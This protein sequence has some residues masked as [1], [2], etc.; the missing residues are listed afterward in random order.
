MIDEY[1]FFDNYLQYYDLSIEELKR[2]KDHTMRVTSYSTL[3]ANELG[4]TR[5]SINLAQKIALFHDIGR[6]PQFTYFKTFND[7]NSIDHG[8]LSH[9]IL[10]EFGYNNPTL[11]KAVRYHNK[12]D[13]PNNLNMMEQLQCKIIRDAD[14]LDN[15]N[16]LYYMKYDNKEISDELMNC[17]YDNRLVP[18]NL[19]VDSISRELRLLSFIFDIYFDESYSLIKRLDIINRITTNNYKITNNPKILEIQDIL[20]NYLEKRIEVKNERV[21]KKIQSRAS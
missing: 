14:K 1:R 20:N 21:R 6:F 12:Y 5:E 17:F 8:N 7:E 11:L 10:C 3:L 16:Q 15:L 9:D 19:A 4:L 18:N 13:I 2:K